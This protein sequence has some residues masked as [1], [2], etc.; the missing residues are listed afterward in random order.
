MKYKQEYKIGSFN[1]DAQGKMKISHLVDYMVDTSIGHTKTI[2]KEKNTVIDL[3]WVIL[4]WDI[5]FY[6]EIKYEDVLKVLTFTTG[7]YKYYAYRQWEISNGH[8]TV[9]VAKSQWL[10]LSK[11]ELKPVRLSKELDSLYESET[12]YD[13]IERKFPRPKKEFSNKM[14]IS[15]RKMDIDGYQHVNNARY[16]DWLSEIIKGDVRRIRIYYKNQI[17]YGEEID[18]QWEEESGKTY[19]QFLGRENEVKTYGIIYY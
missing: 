11:K 18:L 17:L 15:P 6:G 14:A 12:G 13:P 19:F 9:A 4:Q 3:Y 2:E 7:R 8:G 16:F 10:G 5:E 1:L